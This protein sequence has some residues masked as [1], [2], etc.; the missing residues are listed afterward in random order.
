MHKS[1]QEI[2]A[3]TGIYHKIWKGH[4]GE[5]I[6]NAYEQK[7]N[8]LAALCKY[9]TAEISANVK[10]HSYCIMSNHPHETGSV[11][12]DVTVKNRLKKGIKA[13]GN[14]MRNAHSVYGMWY[15]K[16]NARFG[17]VSSARPKT[18]QIKSFADVLNAM[19]YGDANPV[20]AG[21]VN[22]PSKYK[23]SSYNFYAHGIIN[24]YTGS[25]DIPEAYIALGK[26]PKLRQRAYRSLMAA[27]LRKNGLLPENAENVEELLTADKLLAM[28]DS[29]FDAIN[30]IIAL[31]GR[32][33]IENP[34]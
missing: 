29:I 22:H 8:Y 1:R 33:I 16:S 11:G 28:Y 34:G 24:E 18:I 12:W 2:L 15:N 4:N 23:W 13:F 7:Q 14:W 3:D 32:K 9:K 30:G 6:L 5:K 21:I 17:K 19:F 20:R 31:A 10:W 26:S 27:Y 25:L